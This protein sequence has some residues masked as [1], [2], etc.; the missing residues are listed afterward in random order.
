VTNANSYSHTGFIV[1]GP[2]YFFGDPID[3]HTGKEGWDRQA[4]MAKSRRA[5][6][7]CVPK[8]FEAVKEEYGQQLSRCPYFFAP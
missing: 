5:A 6:D 4:W 2:D 7:E 1:V 3:L 8:W